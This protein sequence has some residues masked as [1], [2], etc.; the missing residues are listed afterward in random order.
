MIEVDAKESNF[1]QLRPKSV[2]YSYRKHLV[3]IK[4]PII[5]LTCLLSSAIAQE[6]G[7][8]EHK[9]K[10]KRPDQAR[11]TEFL[12]QLDSDSDGKVSRW[13]FAKGKRVAQ[14]PEE[15]R[16]K[17]FDRLDKNDDGF[18]MARELKPAQGDRHGRFLVKSDKDKDGRISREEFI[19]NPPF[20]QA[21]P[22]RLNKMFDRMD[23]NLDGFLDRKDHVPVGG[24]KRP[25]GDK[26]PP[27]LELK[28][29]DLDENGS[30][31]W[32]EF[33]KAA[34]ARSVP[35]KERRQQFDRIDDDDNGKLDEGELKNYLEKRPKRK[36]RRP[37]PKK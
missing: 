33:K 21:D 22:E 4:T 3:K 25:L 37:E 8:R 16:T 17:I 10:G 28:K 1:L 36:P 29:L 27:R 24:R 6:K 23:E 5:L 31:N 19:A 13:E 15:A 7:E 26:R 9:H 12:K 30:V 14:L 32:Q 34:A 11:A 20:A 18:I 35:E 2:V